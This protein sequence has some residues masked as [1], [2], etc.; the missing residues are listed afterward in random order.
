MKTAKKFI[1]KGRVQGVGFR[2]FTEKIAN[3]I[4]VYGYVKNMYNGSVEVYAIGTEL[5]LKNLK[6]Y[7]ERGPSFARVDRV[8]EEDMDVY[9]YYS[10]SVKF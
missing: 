3:S 1:V 6:E 2:Y 7:L 8:L 10:F 4:G 9:D 5:Q